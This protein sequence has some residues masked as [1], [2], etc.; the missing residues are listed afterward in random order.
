MATNHYFNRIRAANEQ[1][2]TEDLIIESIKIMGL[3]TYY[4]PRTLANKDKLFGEDPRSIFQDHK[5]IEMYVESVNGFDGQ[6]DILSKFGLQVKD[7]L[8]LSV[9]K[10]RFQKETNMPRPLEGDIVYF[11]LTKG[12]FEIKFVEHEPY[13]YQL[14]KNYTFKLRCELFE[15]S[16]EV[17]DTKEPEIDSYATLYDYR[18]T[19][20]LTGT[21]IGQPTIGETIYHY[22]NGS[23]GSTGYD[24]SGVVADVSS[25]YIKIKDVIGSWLATTSS[26][27]RYASYNSGY[28]QIYSITD[29]TDQN[30]YN[31]NQ[32]IQ[33]TGDQILNFD[34]NNPFGDT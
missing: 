25:S 8:V 28:S 32:N 18:M 6:G 3:D 5:P 29:T 24:A 27:T 9:S 16:Q 31:D 34:E 30:N 11:P 20:N 1:N 23:T 13:F 14:G 33:Q 7:N 2:L 4:L 19:L 10:L 17:F 12:F 26:V 15:Y 21:G 22:N